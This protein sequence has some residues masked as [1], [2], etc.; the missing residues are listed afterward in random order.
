MA[1]KPKHGI[2]Y[3]A[4]AYLS[5]RKLNVIFLVVNKITTK[6]EPEKVK[7]EKKNNGRLS[8]YQQ[9]HVAVERLHFNI[10]L[11]NLSVL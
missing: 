2:S 1:H 10:H 5:K 11:C 4:I 9:Y 8:E 6:K 7:N 3:T